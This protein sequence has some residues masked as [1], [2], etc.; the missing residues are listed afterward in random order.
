[1]YNPWNVTWPSANC[2]HFNGISWT[3]VCIQILA[4]SP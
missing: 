4:R 2:W 3:Q 1:M